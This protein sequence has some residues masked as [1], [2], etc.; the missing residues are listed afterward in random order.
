MTHDDHPIRLTAHAANVAAPERVRP[1]TADQPETLTL[2][3][4]TE[5]LNID[6]RTLSEL[7]DDGQIAAT[8]RGPQRRLRADDV[9]AWRSP[10]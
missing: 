10:T 7:V 2:R 1:Q 5:A 9:R 4:A 6:R 3:Q 8:G